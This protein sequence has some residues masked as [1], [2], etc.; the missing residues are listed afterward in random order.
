MR[1][2]DYQLRVAPDDICSTDH[3][4]IGLQYAATSMVFLPVG[5]ALIAL[6][7]RT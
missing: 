7:G 4:V 5:F 1:F 6:Q 2:G 3:K